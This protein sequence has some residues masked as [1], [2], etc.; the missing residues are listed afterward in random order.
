MNLKDKRV[1]ITGGGSGIGFAL[2]QQFLK[3]ECTV[4]ITGRSE[5]TLQKAVHELGPNSGY[6]VCD[7]IST[8]AVK[9][10]ALKCADKVDILIN[11]AGVAY[12]FDYAKND[13]DIEK[14]IHEVDIDLN[15]PI[16]TITSFLPS[17][18]KSENEKAI[19]NISSALALAPLNTVP[20]Y[21]AAKAGLHSWTL[22]LRIQLKKT[23]VKV[24]EVLPPPVQTS[25]ADDM[26]VKDAMS[27]ET[28]AQI[29]YQG[30]E[31]N[32]YEISPGISKLIGY[33]VRIAPNFTVNYLN[34]KFS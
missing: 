31:D 4:I 13:A 21:C 25:M 10:L 27:P 33:L 32:K 22:S 24:F 30:I 20:V 28:I 26:G 11:N 29:I 19:V 8:A 16:R 18:L 6:I 5:A 15:G 17:F 1:L 2:A 9:A 3:K 7:V 12:K 23:K 14:Q 34:N